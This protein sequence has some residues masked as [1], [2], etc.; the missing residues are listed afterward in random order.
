ADEQTTDLKDKLRAL[1]TDVTKVQQVIKE[2]I[3]KTLAQISRS[4]D[5]VSKALSKLFSQAKAPSSSDL[6]N[7]RLRKE[8]GNP[9]G[10][11]NDPLGDQITWEQLLGA[12]KRL[13]KLWV[14][15]K[16][17]DYFTRCDDLVHL[18]PFLFRELA[19]NTP[20]PPEVRCFNDLL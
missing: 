6:A 11:P 19:E 7:A 10:K 15:T 13:S 16:D 2:M 14:I 3:A 1:N 17:A 8:R 5:E 18:N 9:P 12:S 20:A 4:E